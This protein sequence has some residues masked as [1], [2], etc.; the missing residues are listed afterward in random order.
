MLWRACVLLLVAALSGCAGLRDDLIDRLPPAPDAPREPVLTAITPQPASARPDETGFA[1]ILL[2]VEGQPLDTV[3]GLFGPTGMLYLSAAEVL[4]ALALAGGW[5]ADLQRLEARFGPFDRQ[6]YADED[7]IWRLL[8]ERGSVVLG[9]GDVVFLPGEP[10]P[11]LPLTVLEFLTPANWSF[12]AVDLAADGRARGNIP[13]L[14]RRSFERRRGTGAGGRSHNF[15][16]ME[17]PVWPTAQWP[18]PPLL[19]VLAGARIDRESDVTTNAAIDLSMDLRLASAFVSATADSTTGIRGGQA[20]LVT[21]I[22]G[23]EVTA[24]DVDFGNLRFLGSLRGV[25]VAA[26]SGLVD[27]GVLDFALQGTG[28]AGWDVEVRTRGTPPFF[29]FT[30]VGA[31][32]RWRVENAPLAPGGTVFDILLISPSGETIRQARRV[33]SA[34]G[35]PA[36]GRLR[37]RLA[38]LQSGD[39]VFGQSDTGAARNSYAAS[40]EY[41]LAPGFGLRLAGAYLPSED[42]DDDPGSL[43]TLALAGLAFGNTR[44]RTRADLAY[45]GDAFA[46]AFDGSINQERVNWDFAVEARQQG[47]RGELEQISA[48]VRGSRRIGRVSLA[49]EMDHRNQAGDVANLARVSALTSWGRIIAGARAEYAFDAEEA[50]RWN[51]NLSAPLF[52]TG[53]LRSGVRGASEVEEFSLEGDWR[54]RENWRVGL[55]TDYEIRS[56]RWRGRAALSW[57]HRYGVIRADSRFDADGIELGLTLSTSFA[58]DPVR[59]GYRPYSERLQRRALAAIVACVDENSDLECNP[60]EPPVEDVRIEGRLR[61]TDADGVMLLPI[62]PWRETELAVSVGS[63]S[64]P[65]LT[66]I[67]PGRRATIRPGRTQRIDLPLARIGDVT[68]YARRADG[69]PLAGASIVLRSDNGLIDKTLRSGFDGFFF[70]D[71][72]FGRYRACLETEETETCSD[73][74]LDDDNPQ[75]DLDLAAPIPD[76]EG[77]PVSDVIARVEDDLG[78]VIKAGDKLRHLAIGPANLDRGENGAA[79]DAT[80]DCPGSVLAEQGGNRDLQCVIGRPDGNGRLDAETVTEPGPVLRLVEKVDDHINPLLLDPQ[81]RDFEKA[82]GLNPAYPA[83]QRFTRHRPAGN[84]HRRARLHFDRIGGQKLGDDFQPGRV[85]GFQQNGPGSNR[86]GA[87]LH[88]PQDDTVH[89]GADIEDAKRSAGTVRFDQTHLGG[90]KLGPAQLHRRLGMTEGGTSR[91]ALRSGA[92]KSGLRGDIGLKQL[93]LTVIFGLGQGTAGTGAVLIGDRRTQGRFG[94]VDRGLR[95]AA[96]TGIEELRLRRQE[97]GDDIA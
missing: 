26:R 16:G 21:D 91:T 51:A 4:D 83:A 64:D 81:R 14:E 24:G 10:S 49:A 37:W 95:L 87:F 74:R 52:R 80:I 33:A 66:P 45:D 44:L 69:S 3:G 62:Q 31:D 90:L 82:E 1:P 53:R 5:N 71:L 15:A 70:T 75:P 27:E 84:F 18:G 2:R 67:P 47:F 57:R 97:L 59:G 29:A 72:P 9:A 23:V 89:R 34:P 86:P 88:D 63:I 17:L 48:R 8:T 43:D 56:E 50:L 7:G 96:R 94:H 36:L 68:G 85:A 65:F 22:A 39:R 12:D 25:G 58:P 32:G 41:G 40:L 19:D 11:Y 78:A 77:D 20:L 46:A 76:G 42:L 54:G 60:G 13:A 93:Q 73:F 79:I 38:G 6:I 35:A 55:G 61:E 28:P 30:E 92:V